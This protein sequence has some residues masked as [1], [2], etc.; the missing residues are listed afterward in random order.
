MAAPIEMP[1]G[2]WTWVGPA[3]HVFDGQPDPPWEGAILGGKGRPVVK[4][5][6]TVR[7]SVQKRLNLTR[8]RL[9]CGLGST[10]GFMC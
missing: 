9:G 7:S 4:Y 6:D 1:F 8:C 2:L 5:G 10:V 3:N